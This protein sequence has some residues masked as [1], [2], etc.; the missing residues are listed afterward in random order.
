MANV[1]PCKL[2]GKLLIVTLSD[3]LPV[4]RAVVDLPAVV[5]PEPS[6]TTIPAAS[7]IL[8]TTPELG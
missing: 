7:E 2:D 3:P 1:S 8:I 4:V 5:P 6:C